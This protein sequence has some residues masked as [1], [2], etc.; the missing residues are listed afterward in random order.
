MELRDYVRA[1]RR[2]W[3]GIIL[4]TALGVAVAYGWASI[5]T[6]V[7][8]ANASGYLKTRI[9]QEEQLLS[10]QAND[11]FARSKVLTYRDMA[12]WRNVAL[13]AKTELGLTARPEDLV[14]RISVENPDGTSVLRITAT[15]GTPSAARDLAEAWMRGLI[16]TIDEVDGTGEPNTSPVMIVLGESASL[17]VEPAFPDLRAALLVG[18]VVGLGGGIAF[19]MIRAVSDR[20]IRAGDDVEERLGIPVAGT[21]P[22]V[23]DVSVDRRVADDEDE[24]R[25]ASRSEFAVRE[26]L[27]VLRTNLQFMDVDR[28]PRIIVV[29]SALPGEGKSTVA[30]N[31]AVTLA[32]AG[33]PV[34]LI[35]GD[36]RRPTVA[37]TMGLPGGAGLTDVL[38]DRADITEVAQRSPIV[39][40]LVVLT[41]GTIP[42]NPSEVLGS[43]RMHQLLHDLA[44]HAT[45]IIDAPPLLP[46]TDGAVLTHQADGALLVVA[47]GKTSYDLV[48]RAIG[49]IEKVRGRVLGVV[50]NRAPMTGSD[51][52]VYSYEYRTKKTKKRLWRRERRKAGSDALIFPG[53]W[54]AAA[55]SQPPEADASADPVEESGEP[56]AQATETSKPGE[57]VADSTAE[58]TGKDTADEADGS[59]IDDLLRDATVHTESAVRRRTARG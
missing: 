13:H 28:P 56:V 55:R 49:T 5:Q 45:V 34:V 46:V 41:A 36:L 53:A 25:S 18:G 23:G 42:P 12:T 48:D 21:I 30:A 7:Y 27:R 47:A 44:E 31:L 59:E 20:R 58:E 33:N 16:A 10:P 37:K 35:D 43:E 40:A 54:D 8:Q 9:V 2:H 51:S 38:A 39:P 19:A 14:R 50:L 1:L 11:S 22:K 15:G 29:T 32:A 57:P 4:M 17:P 6:P 52:S 26:A 24:R 3:F